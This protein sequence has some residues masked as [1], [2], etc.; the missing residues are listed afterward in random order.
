[1]FFEDRVSEPKF[2]SLPADLERLALTGRA[3]D[4]QFAQNPLPVAEAMGIGLAVVHQQPAQGDLASA[5][6]AEVQAGI[7]ALNRLGPNDVPPAPFTRVRPEVLL[8]TLQVV[9]PAS[10]PVPTHGAP[11]VGHA[12]LDKSQVRFDNAVPGLD[13]P[14]RDLAI[15]MRSI[16]ETFTSEVSLTFLDAYIEAG[17]SE[18][19]VIAL[20]WYGLVAAFR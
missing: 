16:S 12:V 7:D 17:G 15:A 5:T 18:P 11:I 19:S 13:P 4:A 1:M 6:T 9:P 20:D 3:T 2:P 10:A 8:E 14:E